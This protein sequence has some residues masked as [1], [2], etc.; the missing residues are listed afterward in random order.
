MGMDGHWNT[1]ANWNLNAVPSSL[2]DANLSFG[3]VAVTGAASIHNLNLSGGTLSG[4][5]TLS[6]LGAM[7]W[8]GG[9]LSDA[10]SAPMYPPPPPGSGGSSPGTLDIEFGAV[11]NITGYGMK[12]IHGWTINS[13]GI[14]NWTQGDV[15]NVHSTVNIES[16]GVFNISA[17]GTWNDEFSDGLSSINNAGTIVST[18]GMMGMPVSIEAAFNNNGTAAVQQGTLAIFNGGE[19]NGAFVVSPNTSFELNGGVLTA[20]NGA[21]FTSTQQGQ[22]P[23]GW[24]TI[25]SP[26]EVALNATVTDTADMRMLDRGNIQGPGTLVVNGRFTWSGGGMS[27]TG[28]TQINGR[29]DVDFADAP[30]DDLFLSRT[31]QNYGTV[32]L[33]ANE[34]RHLFRVY[35]G[36]SVIN[37]GQFVFITAPN[38]DVVELVTDA[39]PASAGPTVNNSQF[40]VRGGGRAAISTLGGAAPPTNIPVL[41]G[42]SGSITVEAGSLTID[43]YLMNYGYLEA[44]AGANLRFIEGTFTFDPN[45]DDTSDDMMR[46]AGSFTVDDDE[47]VIVVPQNCVVSASNFYLRN[48]NLKPDGDFRAQYFAWSGGTITGGGTTTVEAGARMVISDVVTLDGGTIRDWGLITWEYHE[49]E[50]TI[51]MQNSALIQIDGGRFE[52]FNVNGRISADL[53]PNSV[54]RIVVSNN[55]AFVRNMTEVSGTIWIDVRFEN[56]GGSTEFAGD[57]TFA[58]YSQTLATSVSVFGSGYYDFPSR[59]ALSISGG[60]FRLNGGEIDQ[61]VANVL[62]V[63]NFSDATIYA[64]GRIKFLETGNCDVYLTGNLS[65]GWIDIGITDVW[66]Q[67]NRLSTTNGGT[68]WQ[69]HVYFQG[70]SVGGTISN[71]TPDD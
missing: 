21:S 8:T 50:Q 22:G 40:I 25:R 52:T 47:A 48:G 44:S 67:G 18:G 33:V 11:L 34:A 68:R 15:N 54:N 20:N 51:A 39:R 9:T 60:T 2:D 27:G 10:G 59:T 6:V 7:T 13:G 31:L 46:G 38:G 65:V 3:S 70:G 19:G 1:G 63:A 37:Y 55:G 61:S 36:G 16:T 23:R 26:L 49:F 43:G 24:V 28:T 69:S 4:P 62:L 71:W 14:I 57:A 12:S 17:S 53:G 41:N 30:F 45:T 66:L 32:N 29:M 42:P 35:P 58:S 64:S 5:G 56:N